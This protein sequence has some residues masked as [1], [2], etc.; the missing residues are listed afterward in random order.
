[1]CKLGLLRVRLFGF[2]KGMLCSRPQAPRHRDWTPSTASLCNRQLERT[3]P[4]IAAGKK[5]PLQLLLHS[6]R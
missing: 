4:N 6:I 2:V 3:L 5:R 1:M